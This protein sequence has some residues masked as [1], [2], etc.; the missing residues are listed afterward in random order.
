MESRS[1]LTANH[2]DIIFDG[3]NKNYGAY[4]LRK[5]YSQRATRSTFLVLSALLLMIGGHA[6]ASRFRTTDNINAPVITATDLSSVEVEIPKPPVEVPPPAADPP[7]AAPTASFTTPRIVEDPLVTEPQTTIDDLAN[8]EPG[9]VNSDGDPNGIGPAT[10]T[11]PG[12]GIAGTEPTGIIEAPKAKD[13]IVSYVEQMPAFDG[14]VNKYLANNIQYPPM[15]R[16]SGTKGRVVIRFVVNEDGSVS[17]LT[18]MKGI[19]SGCEEEAIRVIKGMP[20]WRPGKQNGKAVK[21]FFTLPI[22]FVLG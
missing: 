3:R 20:K 13:E 18:V 17:N 19:G 7:P 8:K 14:D 21:V 11:E 22:N 5:N 6:F 10:S 2:L 15:A 9:T 12:T 16:E 1:I 4:E